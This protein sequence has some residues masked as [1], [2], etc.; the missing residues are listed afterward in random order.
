MK[1]AHRMQPGSPWRSTLRNVLSSEDVAGRGSGPW[2]MP[3]SSGRSAPVGIRP[4]GA[5]R[6]TSRLGGRSVLLG[7]L[8]SVV[9]IGLLAREVDLA[10]AVQSLTR[11]NG[12]LLLLP[13]SVFLVAIAL[14]AFRWNHIFPGEARPGVGSCVNALGIGNM[15][16]FLL[17]WRAGDLARCV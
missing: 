16:N 13:L 10:H 11:L 9:C 8:V 12:Y 17:P 7:V 15:A 1:D 2:N 6:T 5:S 14:R 3:D 4:A